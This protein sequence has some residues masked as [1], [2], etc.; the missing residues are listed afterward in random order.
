M[1]FLVYH[2]NYNLLNQVNGGQIVHFSVS[3][4]LIVASRCGQQLCL[5]PVP[6]RYP[7]SPLKPWQ[8]AQL[9][10]PWWCRKIWVYHN[11]NLLSGVSYEL[12][13]NS[14]YY[15][16]GKQAENFT[17]VSGPTT[18]TNCYRMSIS[19]LSLYLFFFCACPCFS[20]SITSFVYLCYKHTRFGLVVWLGNRES[21]RV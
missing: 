8:Y 17:C 18:E 4:S 19:I 15:R 9:G 11:E 21:Y 1:P 20:F 2:Y 12:V 7:G 6:R 3:N 10:L 14:G 13:C 16:A 5:Q